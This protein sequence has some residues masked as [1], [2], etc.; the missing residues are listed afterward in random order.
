MKKNKYLLFLLLLILPL[1][2]NAE[3]YINCKSP[4]AKGETFPCKVT[5]YND[6]IQ[7]FS[8]TVPSD[9]T[10]VKYV[11]ISPLGSFL[12]NSSGRNIKLNSTATNGDVANINFRLLTDTENRITLKF[13]NISYKLD[14]GEIK[15]LAAKN[16]YVGVLKPTTTTTKKVT[17]TTKKVTTTQAQ[18]NKIFTITFN[19][20]NGTNETETKTCNTT[21][22]NCNIS[23]NDVKIPERLSFTF[24][25][26]GN[27]ETCTEGNETTYK[28]TEDTTLYAC[29]TTNVSDGTLYLD[30]LS[31]K[32]QELNF[33]KFNLDYELKVLYEVENLE[34]NAIPSGEHIKT[35]LKESYPLEVGENII[36]IRLL[37]ENTSA[38]N[39][40]TIKVIRL[41][42]GEEIKEISSDASLRTLKIKDYSI[43]FNPE[44]F[45]YTIQVSSKVTSLNITAQ[46][47]DEFAEYLI[48]GNE[49]LNNGSV[50]KITV[51]AEDGTINTYIINIEVVKG[52]EDYLIYIIVGG[53]TL[54]LI[55]VLVIIK[56]NKNKKTKTRKQKVSKTA[57][58]VK[59]QTKNSAVS[60]PPVRPASVQKK[61]TNVITQQV[62]K[63]AVKQT[64]ATPKVVPE[65]V[66]VTPAT[67]KAVP[68]QVPV[69]PATPKAVPEQVPVVPQNIFEQTPLIEPTP[70][71][72][73]ESSSAQTQN[74]GDID[75]TKVETLDL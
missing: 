32:D 59:K 69:T 52:L 50:I 36:E 8:L 53:L 17:T 6:K 66:P 71:I 2:V 25:G 37:D 24:K 13:I 5:V 62:P 42:E 74:N 20:N 27:S 68:E 38:S 75:P 64:P 10:H 48:D 23:L 56:A 47:N 19:H 65:Q 4:V 54:I 55:I 33:S 44:V 29:W 41:N 57:P 30:S 63:T 51:K 16:S 31:I 9:T 35:D 12:D 34:I 1:N 70:N 21:G 18:T 49:N 43:N 15:N 72:Q 11:G 39:I 60:V 46:P 67:P 7:E 45:D 58:S 73:E 28:A 3:V 40:Y 61:T 22:A 26:W 14:D